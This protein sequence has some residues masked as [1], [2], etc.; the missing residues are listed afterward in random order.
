MA[1]VPKKVAERLVAGIKRYQPILSAAKA[2]DGG[3]ADTVPSS[4]TCWLPSSFKPDQK[5]GWDSVVTLAMSASSCRH[6]LGRT[7]S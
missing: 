7:G 6:A 1:A 5:H 3:E 4:R 2:R